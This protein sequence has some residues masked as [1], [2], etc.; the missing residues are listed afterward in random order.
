MN[1]ASFF[2]PG[3]APWLKLPGRPRPQQQVD[4]A[5]GVD[6]SE[7]ARSCHGQSGALVVGKED[8]HHRT[9]DRHSADYPEQLLHVLTSLRGVGSNSTNCYSTIEIC[10][11]ISRSP[12]AATGQWW[13]QRGERMLIDLPLIQLCCIV[14]FFK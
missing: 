2:Y 12:G 11:G 8:P 1:L 7:H 9:Q 3:K 13:Q 14:S 10:C 4:A 5:D 6:K